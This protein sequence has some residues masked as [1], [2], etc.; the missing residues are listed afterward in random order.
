MHSVGSGEREHLDT[1]GGGG[2]RGREGE[3]EEDTTQS[4]HII[5]LFLTSQHTRL[6]KSSSS[7]LSTTTGLPRNL[8]LLSMA[9]TL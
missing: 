3:G 4:H 5:F 6:C 1:G 8:E 7:L 2:G 9:T